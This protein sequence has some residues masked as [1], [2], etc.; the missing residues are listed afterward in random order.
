M[1]MEA[2]VAVAWTIRVWGATRLPGGWT[3][4]PQR[5]GVG[6]H[7][8]A[9]L[10]AGEVAARDQE[11][12]PNKPSQAEIL[13][14]ANKRKLP[15]RTSRPCWEHRR[16]CASCG[17][18]FAALVHQQ[19]RHPVPAGGV[20]PGA[21]PGGRVVVQ[22]LRRRPRLPTTE[23]SITRPVSPYGGDQDGQRV[24]VPGPRPPGVSELSVATLRYFTVYGSGRTWRSAAS[25][26]PPTPAGRWSSTATANRPGTSPRRRRGPGRPAAEGRAGPRPK[27]ATPATP[28]RRHQ[29]RGAARATRPRSPWRT[30]SGARPPGRR[31]G[32]GCVRLR[33]PA[34]PATRRGWRNG[35]RNA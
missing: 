5:P 29:G 28:G 3:G 4:S 2:R 17:R 35:Q 1:A 14:S 27:P 12:P 26:T 34:W 21:P 16:A 33:G 7:P 15:S 18:D 31:G 10:P 24:P 9:Q 25:W 6:P 11:G 20:R 19:P 32:W 8:A 23:E 22:R 13:E 30:A